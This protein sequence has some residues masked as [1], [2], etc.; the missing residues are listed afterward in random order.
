MSEFNPVSIEEAI[1]TCAQRIANGVLKCDIAYRQFLD[2]DRAFDLAYAKAYME[3]DGAA[4]ERKYQAQLVTEVERIKRDASDAAYR[5][6]DRQARALE[7][8]LQSWQSIGAS[9]RQAY[10]VAGRGEF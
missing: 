7:R 1:R 5:L 2:D 8:E 3:A 10:D 4:H 9:V 6:V